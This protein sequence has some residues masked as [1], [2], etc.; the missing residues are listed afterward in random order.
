MDGLIIQSLLILIEL[1]F[2]HFYLSS[3]PVDSQF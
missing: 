2:F 3:V 1:K